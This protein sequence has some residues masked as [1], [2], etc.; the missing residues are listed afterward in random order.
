[1]R[2]DSRSQP[3]FTIVTA[4][5]NASKTITD[6]IASVRAQRDVN[7]E[8]IIIDGGSTDGTMDIVQSYKNSFKHVVSEPDRGAYDA[9]QKGVQ[10]AQGRFCG[11]LNADDYYAGDR[12][13]YQLKKLLE[14]RS[15]FGVS[16]IVEQIE[17]TGKLRRT[18]GRYP[19]RNSDLLWGKFPPH[20]STFIRTDLIKAVGGFRHDFVIAGDFDLFLRVKN[21]TDEPM[22][23]LKQVVTK[24]RLGGLSTK[25]YVN[26]AMVGKELF[27]AL[28]ESGYPA[29]RYKM[30]LRGALKLG[31]LF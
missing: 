24:M 20:P 1:M 3:D 8:H 15:Y 7:I 31:E 11:F 2:V 6:T 19:T 28:D 29:R 22:A 23:H 18:I 30:W 5:F 21:I 10:L 14:V 26:Y 4:C 17:A 9:M 12:V 25:S 16:G 13:L 27:R